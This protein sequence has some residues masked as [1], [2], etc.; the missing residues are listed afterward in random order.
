[1]IWFIAFGLSALT[2]WALFR[3]FRRSK[4][5]WIVVDGSNVLYWHNE[6]P[7][8]HSVK[9]VVDIL[10]GEGFE[11][12]LWFDANAGYLIGDR[13]M[14]PA[15][16]AKKLEMPTASVFVAPKGTPADPLLLEHAVKLKARVVTNDRYRDWEETFPQIRMQGF[17]VRG[18]ISAHDIGLE[19]GPE[20]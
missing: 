6:T 20:A 5:N 9:Q 11:P 17:L 10:R 13:Y 3:A 2:V 18:Y 7:D 14:G 19:L 1:M 4:K 12:L 16:L 15:I 8:L